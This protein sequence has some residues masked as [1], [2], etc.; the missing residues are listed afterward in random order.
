MIVFLVLK[1]IKKSYHTII[2]KFLNNKENNNMN[3]NNDAVEV[4]QSDLEAYKDLLKYSDS[5]NKK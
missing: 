3:I 5:F 1:V 4:P 2:Y